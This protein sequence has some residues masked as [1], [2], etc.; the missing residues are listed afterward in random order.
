MPYGVFCCHLFVTYAALLVYIKQK[1]NKILITP[2]FESVAAAE[3]ILFVVYITQKVITF[4]LLSEKIAQK[5][6]ETYY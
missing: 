1:S 4:L 5:R 2:L 6:E 3:E